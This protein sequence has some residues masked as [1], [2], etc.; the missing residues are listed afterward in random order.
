MNNFEHDIF[1]KSNT[2]NNFFT[3]IIGLFGEPT[4]I[5]EV[6]KDKPFATDSVY[7]AKDFAYKRHTIAEAVENL[8][9]ICHPTVYNDP[10]SLIFAKI[11]LDLRGTKKDRYV[12]EFNKTVPIVKTYERNMPDRRVVCFVPNEELRIAALQEGAIMAGGQELIIEV[13]KGRVDT[14]NNFLNIG[15][16]VTGKQCLYS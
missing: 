2:D 12:D 16:L 1:W 6:D 8:K 9:Q 11:E 5:R 14:V 7:F 10:E 4:P 15:I 3:W 13:S